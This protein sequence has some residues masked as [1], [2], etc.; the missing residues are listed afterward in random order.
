VKRQLSQL[1]VDQAVSSLTTFALSVY[2]ARDSSVTEFGVFAVGY[3]LFWV[4]LG[5]SRSFVGEVNLITGHEKLETTGHWRSF[6]ATTSLATGVASAIV[7]FA[8]CTLIASTEASWIPWCFALAAPLAIFADA[9]RY[10]AFAEE[11][12]GDALLLDGVWLCGALFAPPAIGALGLAPVPSALIGWGLGAALGA[13]LALKRQPQLRPRLNGALRWAPDRRIMGAQFAAD[14][15]AGN[16]VG[17]A[18]TALVPVVASLAAAGGLRAGYVIT[19]PLNVV[20]SAII[21][22]LIP[23]LRRSIPSHHALPSPAPI[24]CAAFAVFCA[25]CAAAVRLV[26]DRL[27][28]FLLGPSWELGQATAPLLIAAFYFLIVVQIIVQ[29]MRLRGS[30]GV[31]IPVRLFVS[32]L[33]AVGLLAGAALF[34]AVGAASGFA[35]AAL[36]SIAPWWFALARSRSSS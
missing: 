5:V 3:A 29:V 27:G 9:I 12:Y 34:G 18:A 20:Y 2:A 23:R 14:F 13:G 33:Q 7:L 22:F 30:A 10:V 31:I 26:P 16:G 32:A 8:G 28:E 6:S 21:V 36:I 24:V 4:L 11:N 17:Q 19:G 1:A 35:L 25:F 15:L